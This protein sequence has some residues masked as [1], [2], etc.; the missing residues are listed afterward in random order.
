MMDTTHRAEVATRARLE[1]DTVEADDDTPLKSG[2]GRL[3][4]RTLPHPSVH[5]WLPRM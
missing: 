4:T 1:D 5:T 2:R 3:V